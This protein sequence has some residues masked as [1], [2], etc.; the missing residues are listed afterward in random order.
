MSA[1]FQDVRSSVVLRFDVDYDIKSLREQV[2]DY[3]EVSEDVFNAYLSL[4]GQE[5]VKTKKSKE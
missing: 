1:Y 5:P 3:K 2:G 4:S